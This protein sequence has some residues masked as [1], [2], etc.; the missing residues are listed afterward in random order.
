MLVAAVGAFM[1]LAL[2]IRAQVAQVVA[3]LAGQGMEVR[4]LLEL[5]IPA[6]V[7]VVVLAVQ[8]Q[9]ITAALAVQ[10]SSSCAMQILFQ[11]LHQLQVPQ[12]SP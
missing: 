7:G 5:Q 6:V 2:I 8:A 4:V 1:K 9:A 11:Q 10:A 12:P 3:G